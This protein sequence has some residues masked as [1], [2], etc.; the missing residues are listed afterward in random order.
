MKLIEVVFDTGYLILILGLGCRL[1]LGP[2]KSS[3]LFGVMAIL[4]G[5]GDGFHLLPRILSHLSQGAD[6]AYA[7]HLGKLLTGISMSLFYLLF[8]LA[9]RS[10]RE[11][12]SRALDVL[13]A[14]SFIAR[15]GL[16]LLPQNGW[17]SGLEDSSIALWRNVPFIIMGIIVVWLAYQDRSANYRKMALYTSGSFLFYLPVVFWGA[18]LPA[19]GLLMMPKTVMYILLVFAFLKENKTAPKTRLADVIV[20]FL[21][22]GL[23]AGVLYREFTKWFRFSGKTMLAVIHP[24]SLILGMA[25]LLMFFIAQYYPSGKWFKG[26]LAGLYF[27]LTMMAVRGLSQVI[28]APLTG[29]ENAMISGLAGIG[30]LLL[31]V[32][33]SGLI[34]KFTRARLA[35]NE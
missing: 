26:Y 19:L 20:S 2:T 18:S 31:G 34:I 7:M 33:L 22:M 30:H 29:A 10:R 1:L 8:Y 21:L 15:I 11:K 27:T 32:C 24:H 17:F 28:E 12:P 6:Y 16:C 9:L 5:L 4:L 13:M 35:L 3:Q 23:A 14:L 25:L